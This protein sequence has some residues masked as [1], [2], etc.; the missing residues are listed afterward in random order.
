MTMEQF[1]SDYAGNLMLLFA[2]GFGIGFL[3]NMLRRYLEKL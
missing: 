2:T 3:I 1:V